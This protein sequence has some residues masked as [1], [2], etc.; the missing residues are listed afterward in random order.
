ML[1]PA[2]VK[3]AGPKVAKLEMKLCDANYRHK[4]NKLI[5]KALRAAKARV[6]EL[7]H[8]FELRPG[9]DKGGNDGADYKHYFESEFFHQEM[10][11]M[12]REAGLRA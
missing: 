5:P 3:A 9:S 8:E 10:N 4:I 7:E 12:A 1:T 11:Q 6:A 2:Q